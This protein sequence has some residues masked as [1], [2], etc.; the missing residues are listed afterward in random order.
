MGKAPTMDE[1]WICSGSGDI[2]RG[3]PGNDVMLVDSEIVELLNEQFAEIATLETK[4]E[5]LL[6]W[7]VESMA[8]NEGLRDWKSRVDAIGWVDLGMDWG[9]SHKMMHHLSLHKLHDLSKRICAALAPDEEEP[10][11]EP[12]P[13]CHSLCN[14]AEGS[15]V[16]GCKKHGREG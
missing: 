1:F 14:P 6:K 13:G 3:G 4:V 9:R 15:H 16:H 12:L 7:E 2:C 11:D 10:Q 8:E 5:E